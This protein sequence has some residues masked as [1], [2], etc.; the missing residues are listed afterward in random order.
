MVVWRGQAL[1]FRWRQAP[2][3]YGM[4]DAGVDAPRRP[5]CLLRIEVLDEELAAIG[6]N[7]RSVDKA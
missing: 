1:S 5:L 3:P 6:G 4:E 2:L 7:C